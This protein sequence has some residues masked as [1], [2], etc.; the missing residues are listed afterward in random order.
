MDQQAIVDRIA[1]FEYW[2]YEFDLQGVKTPIATRSRVNRHEQRVK[3]FLEPLRRLGAL[4]GKRVLDLGCN[5]GFWS[6]KCLEF[7]AV[8]VQGID[9]HQANIDQAMFV[10]EA[11]GVDRD[12]FAFIAADMFEYDLS[13]LGQFDVV[14]NL[15]LMYHISRP[16]ELLDK[17]R[18]VNTDLLVIDTLVAPYTESVFEVRF[19]D[20]E[21]PRN[22]VDRSAVLVPSAAA[23]RDIVEATGYRSH[24]LAQNPIDDYTGM[25]DYKLGL[26][27]A[28]IGALETDVSSLPE[29]TDLKPRSSSRTVGAAQWMTTPLVPGKPIGRISRRLR[30][31]LRRM[32]ARLSASWRRCSDG[33]GWL[34]SAADSDC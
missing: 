18:S 29:A 31:S 6:L 34:L 23:L 9:G 7:G 2:H 14:L 21:D 10:F 30:K 12:K 16:V 24:F 1:Q 11:K 26:R 33:R 20:P 19:E 4:E 32:F 22:A 17:I 3:Y 27:W 8:F 5:S 25:E 13:T 15:G 28:L